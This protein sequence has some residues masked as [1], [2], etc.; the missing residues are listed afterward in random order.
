MPG[1]PPGVLMMTVR[2]DEADWWLATMRT[3]WVWRMNQG[4]KDRDK[5][6]T[7]SPR[8]CVCVERME[9]TARALACVLMMA[10]AWSTVWSF[11]NSRFML[12]RNSWWARG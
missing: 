7:S 10:Y 6:M 1:A 9:H 5:G 4:V 12:R 3:W 11:E 8:G 2:E